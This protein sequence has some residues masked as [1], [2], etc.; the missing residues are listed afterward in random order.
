MD[1]ISTTSEHDFQMITRSNMA[2]TILTVAA[3]AIAMICWPAA[4][5]AHGDLHGQILDLTQRIEKEPRNPELYLA[6]GELQRAHEDWDSAQADYD[7][8]LALNPKL[9]IIDFVRGRLFFE[10]NW[11]ISAKISLD[12]FLKKQTNHVEALVTRARTLRKLENRVAAARDYTR[13]IQFTT[14]SR[15]ELYLERAQTLVAEGGPYVKE[16]LQ[17]LDEGIR[18]LGPL[19]TLELNAIDIEVTRKEYDGAITRLDAIAAKSP[20]KE[21][22][23]ARKGDILQLAGRTDDA[24]AAFTSAL[25]A[26]ET[27][28]PGRRN[29]PAMVELQERIKAQLANLK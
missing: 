14:E 24:R 10:A 13:A 9:E 18:K 22:W 11:P 15:P 6:R 21:T 16:A 3:S 20:R 29:V 2:R 1:C 25:E 23:L 8:A 19:V 27:L 7:F 28:P 26:M 17:G 4:V 12:R 5:L